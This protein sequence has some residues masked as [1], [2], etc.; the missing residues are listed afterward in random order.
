M[1]SIPA[2]IQPCSG[3]ARQ[4]LY[5]RRRRKVCSP[6]LGVNWDQSCV[7]SQKIVTELLK[8]YK[9]VLDEKRLTV[10]GASALSMISK[11]KTQGLNA[12][13]HHSKL[14]RE[15]T[16]SKEKQPSD[17]DFIVADIHEQYERRLQLLK[18][19]DF[20]DLLVYGV[21]LFLKHEIATK[22]CQHILVDEL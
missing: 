18:S 15:Q 10:T 7:S 16:L 9:E 17:L 2:Q 12:Q 11:I 5:L 22:W 3:A 8:S 4:L 14:L 20:D 6:S 1:C 21:D 13:Q 19:L